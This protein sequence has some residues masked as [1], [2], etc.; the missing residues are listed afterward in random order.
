MTDFCL[1]TTAPS[2]Q[3]ARGNSILKEG[4]QR[5]AAWFSHLSSLFVSLL[6]EPP[7]AG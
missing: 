7:E 2:P 5:A 6:A 1:K 3:P 4:C